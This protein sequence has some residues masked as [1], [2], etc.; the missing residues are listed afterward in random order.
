MA[1]LNWVSNAIS[2]APNWISISYGLLSNWFKK[3]FNRF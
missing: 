3:V 2:I 1:S